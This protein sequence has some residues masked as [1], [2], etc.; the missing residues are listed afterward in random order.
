MNFVPAYRGKHSGEEKEG[1]VAVC[2]GF[3]QNADGFQG[4][5]RIRL[6]CRVSPKTLASAPHKAPTRSPRR[7]FLRRRGLQKPRTNSTP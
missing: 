6:D 4:G 5:R 1:Q 2:N 3:G 7:V